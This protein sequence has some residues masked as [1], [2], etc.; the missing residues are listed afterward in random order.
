MG[1]ATHGQGLCV[2][3]ALWS[4]ICL[5][6]CMYRLGS[7]GGGRLSAALLGLIVQPGV[8]LPVVLSND[9]GEVGCGRGER[10]A[11]YYVVH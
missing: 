9:G 2:G 1:H 3:G 11:T 6:T 8:P 10:T 5:S 7:G 4:I